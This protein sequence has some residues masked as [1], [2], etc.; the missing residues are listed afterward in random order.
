MTCRRSIVGDSAIG[1]CF[2]SMI[3]RIGGRK[4][5]ALLKEQ[6]S[7]KQQA[8]KHEHHGDEPLRESEKHVSSAI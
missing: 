5:V 8:G 1:D 6:T 4:R 3:I 2:D 7:N